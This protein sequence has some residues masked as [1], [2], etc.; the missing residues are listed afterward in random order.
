MK[1]LPVTFL[2]KYR[3]IKD[4]GHHRDRMYM[5]RRFPEFGT[6]VIDLSD[7]SFLRRPDEV[8]FVVPCKGCK[9]CYCFLIDDVSNHIKGL[10]FVENYYLWGFHGEEGPDTDTVLENE[11]NMLYESDELLQRVIYIE[12]D[13]AWK[14]LA[15][16]LEQDR[17]EA[18]IEAMGKEIDEETS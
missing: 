7:A 3:E 12:E 8:I 10:G 11:A 4:T 14:M 18:G 16:A 15:L 5:P 17:Y 9:H 2:N 1:V 13:Q 6:G